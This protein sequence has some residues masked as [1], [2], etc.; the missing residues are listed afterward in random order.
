MMKCKLTCLLLCVAAASA[1]ATTPKDFGLDDYLKLYR[2]A[3]ILSD[4]DEMGAIREF[5]RGLALLPNLPECYYGKAN[6]L[7]SQKEY[8]KAIDVI[9]ILIEKDPEHVDALIL[10]G[11]AYYNLEIPIKKLKRQSY[12]SALASLS[13]KIQQNPDDYRARAKRAYLYF[14]L[15]DRDTGRAEIERILKESPGNQD[16]RVQRNLMK[17]YELTSKP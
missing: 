12:S 6:V 11:T 17:S 10:Q 1:C 8:Q 3:S 7:M 13:R 16:A 9:K 5:D 14:V 15:G 4:R 2:E